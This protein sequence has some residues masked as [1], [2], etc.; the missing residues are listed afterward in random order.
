MYRREVRKFLDTRKDDLTWGK[1][2]ARLAVLIGK[3]S[4]TV[5]MFDSGRAMCRWEVGAARLILMV[6]DDVDAREVIETVAAMA[7]L[8]ER[9]PRRFQDDA[10]FMVQ[11][12]RRFA[13]LTDRWAGQYWSEKTGSMHKVYHDVPRRTALLL[14]RYLM[15]AIGCI[16]IYMAKA[17]AERE[18]VDREARN[19]LFAALASGEK[20]SV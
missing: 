5:A 20:E 19:A 6:T 15:V 3:A 12:C 2:G 4:D 16:G 7:L 10:A 17:Q 1:A 14:G 13:G 18:R 9:D 11:C 8:R